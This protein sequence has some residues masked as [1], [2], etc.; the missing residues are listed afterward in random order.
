M[1]SKEIVLFVKKRL[2]IRKV[3]FIHSDI[4][5]LESLKEFSIKVGRFNLKK[6]Q[7]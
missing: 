7:P 6:Q 5:E 1:K 4:E 3:N 2:I